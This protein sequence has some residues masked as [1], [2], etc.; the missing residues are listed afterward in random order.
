MNPEW[1][2]C[3]PKTPPETETEHH[4][5][6]EETVSELNT[7]IM[8]N[9]DYI[10]NDNSYG[11]DED[12]MDDIH[13][14]ADDHNLATLTYASDADDLNSDSALYELINMESVINI[15]LSKPEIDAFHEQLYRYYV[16]TRCSE[17]S[18]SDR[19]D[20]LCLMNN[21]WQKVLISREVDKN[22]NLNLKM[23]IVIEEVLDDNIRYKPYVNDDGIWVTPC[24]APKKKLKLI[25]DELIYEGIIPSAS[26]FGSI[27]TGLECEGS[28]MDIT[29]PNSVDHPSIDIWF[30][31]NEQK[32]KLST[33]LSRFNEEMTS[34][35]EIVNRGYEFE[36][37]P[38]L[39]AKVPILK[40]RETKQ[41]QLE[42]DIAI[43]SSQQSVARLINFYCDYDDRVRPFII[44]IK[45][46]SKTRALCDAMNN[47]PNSFGFV[48]LCIKYLQ[49]VN[50]IP[51]CCISDGCEGIE[52]VKEVDIGVPNT[53]TLL[54]LM[55]QFFELY[56]RFNFKLLQIST[57]RTGLEP[58]ICHEFYSNFKYSHQTTMVVEDPSC[59]SVNVT[60]HV[61]P[62]RLSIMQ[63]EFFR[64]YMCCK[65]GDWDFLMSSCSDLDLWQKYEP[66]D[67]EQLFY[68]KKQNSH[69]MA[70]IP[71]PQQDDG[72]RY[73]TFSKI[74]STKL[75]DMVP[76]QEID[77]FLGITLFQ[78]IQIDVDNLC[79]MDEFC[80]ICKFYIIQFNIQWLTKYQNETMSKYGEDEEYQ[81]FVSEMKDANGNVMMP[82]KLY[83]YIVT[84]I[85]NS[86]DHNMYNYSYYTSF[87]ALYTFWKCL[88]SDRLH[89]DNMFAN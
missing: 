39:N 5:E 83:Q 49:M 18:C 58:K 1:I 44:A 3:L 34:N 50:I 66:V 61:R 22:V 67:D 41:T 60:R 10:Y 35:T 62:Y 69:R 82:N 15:E 81:T 7:Y 48:L 68:Y 13:E 52:T 87:S 85:Y 26:I 19:Y 70:A 89:E 51:I 30:N 72:K 75:D 63:N 4:S 53:D 79:N 64:G 28:D 55:V 74:L 25:G 8:N 42:M 20:M 17:K 31:K 6:Q 59:R 56:H 76:D 16:E 11:D 27:C 73:A 65:N 38:V 84:Q 32:S 45:H 78:S 71:I 24:F 37:F 54:E 88:F 2:E 21:I 80:I 9:G 47:Y 57:S 43:Q 36:I 77:T 46:W 12:D 14:Y 40:V 33:F 86:E 29:L 23:E